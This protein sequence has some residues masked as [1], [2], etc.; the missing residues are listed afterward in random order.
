MG[1]MLPHQPVT[2][3][4]VARDQ[5]LQDGFMV[6]LTQRDAPGAERAWVSIKTHE[7]P[8]VSV[9]EIDQSAISAGE[10]N[11]IVKVKV[12]PLAVHFREFVGRHIFL[13]LERQSQLIQGLIGNIPGC[14]PTGRH[15]QCLAHFKKF[16]EFCFR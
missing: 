12:M 13:Q 16:G 14:Q 1:K 9:E 15:F 8:D 6:S 3:V 2:S 4:R 5:R 11:L 7:G 10:R